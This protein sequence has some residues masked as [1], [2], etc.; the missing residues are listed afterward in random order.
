M[1]RLNYAVEI[2]RYYKNE[3]EVDFLVAELGKPQQAIQ[4]CASNP[5]NW[6]F[7]LCA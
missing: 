3:G 5:L 2:N 4:E 7:Q 6:R 1:D